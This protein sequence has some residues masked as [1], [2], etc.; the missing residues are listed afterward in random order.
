[1]VARCM[2]ER[3]DERRR[4]VL[5]VGHVDDRVDRP[6]TAG[7]GAARSDGEAGREPPGAK[8]PHQRERS[9]ELVSRHQHAPRWRGRTFAMRQLAHS[10]QP[11]DARRGKAR[12]AAWSAPLTAERPC[13]QAMWLTRPADDLLK[14]WKRT[15][16]R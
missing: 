10:A 4:R 3:L 8:G 5:G 9:V 6:R 7:V 2:R 16:S 15:R 12:L 11:D 13:V 14:A 1:Q